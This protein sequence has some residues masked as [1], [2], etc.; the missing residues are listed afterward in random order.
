ME[1]PSSTLLVA[2]FFAIA[3][4]L[5]I[6]MC[7]GSGRPPSEHKKTHDCWP[8][9]GSCR[10]SV[11]ARQVPTASPPTTTTSR[12]TCRITNISPQ[13]N[14]FAGGRQVFLIECFPGPQCRFPHPKASLG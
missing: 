3:V 8:A 13:S 4:V 12:T 7:C 14:E 6:Y 9:V 11:Y 1:G 2:A 5:L 10:N